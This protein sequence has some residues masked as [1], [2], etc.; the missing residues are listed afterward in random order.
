VLEGIRKALPQAT[1]TY[2]KGC[3][4]LGT[5]L[6]DIA[7]AKEIAAKAEVAIVVVGENEWRSPGHTGTDGEGFDS[8]T[9][10]LTGVQEQLIQA[11]HSTGTPTIVVLI[12]G[13]PLAT[14]WIAQHVPAV[15][16]AWLPGEQGGTAVAEILFGDV[17]PSGRLP[18]SIP[19]HAGQLPVYYNAKRSKSYW[20]KHGWGRPYVDMEPT[21]L[22]PFGFG[23]TYT[24][25]EHSELEVSAAVIKPDENLSVQVTTKNS[26]TRAGAEVVQLY[27]QDVISSVSRPARELRGFRKLWLKPGESKS[28]VFTLTPDDLALYTTDLRR[29]VEPGE[30][31]L[32]VASSSE[33]SGLE[34]SFR[35]EPLAR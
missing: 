7:R 5:N 22:Y 16:E 31:K 23:L 10:E 28:C 17:N 18:V 21:P 13:R 29:V 8:A 20:V 19:R 12:N 1:V 3:E 24:R 25:F 15:L 33:D 32:W 30:F 27:V 14:R 6:N 9:L 2:V 35:V 34:A 4:V 11:V 26:G